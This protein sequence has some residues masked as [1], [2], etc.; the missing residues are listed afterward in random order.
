MTVEASD[1]QMDAEAVTID[2]KYYPT[3]RFQILQGVPFGTRYVRKPLRISYHLSQYIP[4]NVELFH[5]YLS[6]M[7][8]MSFS[9][10]CADLIL[11]TPLIALF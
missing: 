10:K 8:A 9:S 3:H 2:F 11:V 1:S 7:V 5:G 4:P 6:V